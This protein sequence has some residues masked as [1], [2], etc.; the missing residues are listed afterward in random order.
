[1]V[2]M[3]RRITLACLYWF[4]AA[5]AAQGL[6]PEVDAA[7]ARARVPRDAVSLYVAPVDAPGTPRLQHRADALVNPASLAKLATTIAG[8]ELLGPAFTWSTPVYVDGPVVDGVLQ[9]HVYLQGRGDPKLVQERLWLLL[10]RVQGLGIRRISGDIV[11]DRSAFD[12]P[13]TDPGAFD[14]EPLR[15]YNAAPD[16]LLLNFKSVVLTFV[17][18]GAQARVHAEPPLAGVQW[19]A[20]VPLAGGECNDW[21]GALKADF[22]DPNRP[23]FAG[24]Y[25]AA[26]AERV[27]PLAF[28]EPASYAARAVAGMWQ[29]I[30]GELAG[31]VREGRVPAGLKPAFEWTSPP[32]AE[33]VRDINKFSNNVMAQQLFLTLA[34]Q[35]KGTGTQPAARD[36]LRAWWGE[37]FGGEPPVMDNGS[38]LSRSERAT[39]RQLAQLLH[40]A[41]AAPFMPELVA[42][43]PASGQDGTLRRVR[44]NVGLA[45]LKT[46]SLNNVSGIAGYVH[47]P[48]GRRYVLVA[49]ANGP[50][51]GAARPAFEAL[52]EWTARE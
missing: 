27:W 16:A 47:G 37:R 49:V 15:P 4:A 12:V 29:S 11:L 30:G 14:G 44:R 46:G 9:G 24:A 6:P 32:L 25:P 1:M 2:L 38:G 50:G 7:L 3:V 26:C 36:L 31:S 40:A 43:L 52:V 23:R 10:R 34:L 13:P 48:G 41:W 42:S 51:A 39:A 19:P 20:T 28:P 5:C 22:S 21:R 8:L 33:I 35:L 17:P 18:Q 45:H